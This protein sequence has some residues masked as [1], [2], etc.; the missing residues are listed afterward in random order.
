MPWALGYVL[1]T[2]VYIFAPSRVEIITIPILD[3]KR[4]PRE[5]K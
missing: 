1:Y 3:M 2:L 5:M 4:R